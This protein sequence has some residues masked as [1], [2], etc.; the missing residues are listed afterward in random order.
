MGPGP[1][2]HNVRLAHGIGLANNGI[3]AGEETR[4]L[5]L[6][7]KGWKKHLQHNTS[8]PKPEIPE[9]VDENSELLAAIQLCEIY[10]ESV[11]ATKV[12]NRVFVRDRFHDLPVI[13][14]DSD[15][16]PQH[17]N[18][19]YRRSEAFYLANY[20]LNVSFT[21]D[22]GA[23]R[24]IPVTPE[25]E[26][27]IDD[28]THHIVAMRRRSDRMTALFLIQNYSG[29]FVAS[30]VVYN[31]EVWS[32][33][34]WCLFGNEPLPSSFGKNWK[35]INYGPRYTLNLDRI[36]VEE[37]VG[38]KIISF[39]ESFRLG[40]EGNYDQA[41][42]DLGHRM[43]ETVIVLVCEGRRFWFI[44]HWVIFMRG[45]IVCTYS[46]VM[47]DW[48]KLCKCILYLL[49]YL[50]ESEMSEAEGDI[51][52]ILSKESKN[53]ALRW[54]KARQKFLKDTQFPKFFVKAAKRSE[55][56]MP[57][58]KDLGIHLKLIKNAED[59][60]EQI[61]M[62]TLGYIGRWMNEIDKPI[63]ALPDPSDDSS[64]DSGEEA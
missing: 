22:N 52:S 53:Q 2:P 34:N 37:G 12:N 63:V 16:S 26:A 56:V 61:M 21:L 57:T 28:R 19:F 60:W 55:Q 8:G 44:E 13:M 7:N 42:S 20:P 25:Q 5:R 50:I 36:V 11:Y 14:M 9:P 39:F 46:I 51:M 32:T 62:R 41:T 33:V 30:K 48:L 47:K 23:T 64:D 4:D 45:R 10:E 27:N 6:R 24:T 1:V 49:L 31:L 54:W 29:Y 58:I 15:L 43:I 38:N 40:S 59:I 35:R 3:R 18:A 17:M